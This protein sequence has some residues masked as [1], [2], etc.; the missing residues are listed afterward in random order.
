MKKKLCLLTKQNGQSLIL[1]ILISSLILL[2]GGA[3]LAIG[4]T[5][6]KTAI[7]ESGQKRAYYIAEAGVEKALAI[8]KDN[9][10]W[11]DSLKT[12]TVYNLLPELITSHYGDGFIMFVKLTKTGADRNKT[13]LTIESCGSY[14]Q[15]SRTVRARVEINRPLNFHAGLWIDAP[16]TGAV[17]LHN[18][19]IDSDVFVNGDMEFLNDCSF[20]KNAWISG[21]LVVKN[22]M[23]FTPQSVF[24]GGSAEFSDNGFVSGSIQAVGIVRLD[25]NSVFS[26]VIRTMGDVEI[27][28][29]DINDIVEAIIYADGFVTFPSGSE[30]KVYSNGRNL[31][32]TLPEFPIPDFDWY[33]NNADCYYHGNNSWNSNNLIGL[34]GI[35]YIDGDLSIHGTYSGNATV[36]VNGNVNITGSLNAKDFNE[37]INAQENNL[38]I[39]SGGDI[40]V[41]GAVRVN[42]LLYTK[43]IARLYEN[44]ELYGSLISSDIHLDNNTST[45]YWSSLACRQPDWVTSGIRIMSW[46]E[47]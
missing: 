20:T 31:R 16:N 10:Q 33:R 41:T 26:G 12:G 32:F 47:I 13:Y 38:C 36:V 14:Q 24:V 44:V 28:N 5:V 43:G 46:E 17:K 34:E 8:V 11:L 42:S 25:G 4:T 23:R 22:N 18:A 30:V 9:C 19:R 35:H 45:I 40:S 2:A 39:I 3:A 6:S 15:S 1:V 37:N 7:S 27:V 21:D 29:N